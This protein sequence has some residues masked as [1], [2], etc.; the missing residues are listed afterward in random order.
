[1]DS[2]RSTAEYSARL[3]AMRGGLRKLLRQARVTPDSV[4]ACGELVSIAPD[5]TRW[6]GD[7]SAPAALVAKAID[8]ATLTIDDQEAARALLGLDP[9]TLGQPLG[10]RREVAARMA[11]VKTESFRVHREGRLL[12]QLAQAALIELDVSGPSGAGGVV[13][14]AAGDITEDDARDASLVGELSEIARLYHECLGQGEFGQ[15]AAEWALQHLI[16]DTRQRLMEIV[17][18]RLSV[19][20]RAPV[21]DFWLHSVFGRAHTNIWT[22][23]LGKPGAN[24]GGIADPHMLEAQ[25]EAR[26]RGVNITRLFVYDPDMQEWEVLHRRTV[27]HKQLEAGVD[28]R[29]I[30]TPEFVRR[31]NAENATRRIGS[32]DFMIID[33]AYVYLTFPDV[34]DDIAASLLDGRQHAARLQAARSFRQVLDGCADRVTMESLGRFPEDVV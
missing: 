7:A 1:M 10:A 29:A 3:D 20:N 32:A 8:A 30:T 23:N 13:N 18:G 33:D 6:A 9:S 22:T 19:Q 15:L 25:V 24:M 14:L 5:W 26:S 27:M 28:V 12:D 17:S 31:A 21:R 2:N 11:G 16:A 4:L 34:T